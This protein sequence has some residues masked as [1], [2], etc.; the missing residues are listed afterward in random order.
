MSSDFDHGYDLFLERIAPGCRCC[1]V[2][3]ERPCGGCQAGA[4]CDAMRCRC[5]D[6]EDERDEPDDEDWDESEAVR[7][8]R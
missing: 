8:D 7:R 3:W 5:D 1:P 6:D 2:C 4:P